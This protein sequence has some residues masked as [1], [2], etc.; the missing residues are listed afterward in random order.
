[1]WTTLS[2]GF[3]ICPSAHAFSSLCSHTL[4]NLSSNSDD[5]RVNYFLH[6]HGMSFIILIL[7]NETDGLGT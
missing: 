4:L 5:R 1:M 7:L 3:F 6:I 2:V